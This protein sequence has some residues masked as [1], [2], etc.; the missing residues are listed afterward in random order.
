MPALLSLSLLFAL[1]PNAL[2]YLPYN[3]SLPPFWG[4]KLF[5]RRY[6]NINALA[7]LFVS[8]FPAQPLGDGWYLPLLEHLERC[9]NYLGSNLA[10]I[11]GLEDKTSWVAPSFSA[12]APWYLHQWRSGAG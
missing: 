5:E 10:G 1:W 12:S 2:I 6:N 11:W 9:C 7:H 3:I 4:Y 8:V